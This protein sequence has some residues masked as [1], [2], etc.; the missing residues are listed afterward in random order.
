MVG[1]ETDVSIQNAGNLN[2][3]LYKRS[4]L[5]VNND[6][7]FILGV[8]EKQT[9]PN[10]SNDDPQPAIVLSGAAAAA[11]NESTSG[12]AVQGTTQGYNPSGTSVAPDGKDSAE[13]NDAVFIRI[14]RDG[15]TFGIAWGETVQQLNDAEFNSTLTMTMND[16]VYIG[17][18]VTSRPGNTN[19]DTKVTTT[20]NNV[21][22]F[23]ST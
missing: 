19:S 21:A 12:P 13:Y 10:T 23:T 4:G 15:S 8:G 6:D 5:G 1:L 18:F 20:F 3:V 22:A 9:D 17:L 7:A 16:N 14:T 11:P 2:I